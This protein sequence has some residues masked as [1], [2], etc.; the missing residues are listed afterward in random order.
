[1]A[2]RLWPDRQKMD[3]RLVIALFA[4][5]LFICCMVCHGEL[6]R[7]KPHPRHLTGFYVIVSLGGALGGLFV[8]LFAPNVFHAYYEF[9]IGLAFCALL[10]AFVFARALCSAPRLWMQT[11]I[12]ILVVLLAGYFYFLRGIMFQMVDGYLVVAR[13]FYGQLRVADEGDPRIDDDASRKLIHGV[14]NH[15]QQ[16]LRDEYRRLPVSYFCPE[17]GIGR[18]MKALEGH[19]RRIGILG[20]G[21]GTL[22]AY[23]RPGDTL[24]IYEINPQVVE[25]ARRDF[26]YLKDTP[27]KVE[28]AMGDAR[29]VLDG[30]STEPSQLFDILVMD[31]FSGDSVPVHLITREA[32]A[33]YF[34]HLKP[35]GILAVNISNAYLTLDPVMERG[36]SALGKVALVYHWNPRDDDTMCFSCSWTLIMDPAT[37]AAHPELQRQA[38]LLRQERPFRVWTDDF[39]NMFTVLK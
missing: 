4:F 27:A 12:S 18:G 35:T 29:L 31:A 6:A 24:R 28:I 20:L 3:L 25:I 17:S 5:A 11:G 32:F 1:M 34:R 9:P 36:A 10:T 8:G 14:I 2:Y 15:G 38:K 33:S 7:L 23:G 37:A 13:N 30:E 21:C 22:A 16:M 19:P 26:S 39:S